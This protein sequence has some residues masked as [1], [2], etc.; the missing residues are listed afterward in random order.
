MTASN[1]SAST[2][3]AAPAPTIFT[4]LADPR[5]HAR[6]DGSGT[7]RD[8]VDGPARLELGSTFG[9]KMKVGAPYRTKNKVVEYDADRLI[10][11]RH[12]GPHRWRYELEQVDGGTRVTETWDVSHC[13]AINRWALGAMGYPKRH[14][15]GIEQTL[16]KLKAAAEADAA[17][18]V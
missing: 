15:R 17:G 3:I 6:I 12:F 4:I 11:W 2:T 8:A 1:V 10:A 13:N 5:Q 14:Q 16:V 18:A 9:M 7:V